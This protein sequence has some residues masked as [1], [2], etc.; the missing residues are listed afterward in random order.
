M[1]KRMKLIL[2]FSPAAAPFIQFKNLLIEW[3]QSKA[4]IDEINWRNLMGRSPPTWLP[5]PQTA[6]IQFPLKMNCLRC[7][8]LPRSRS[9]LVN[10]LRQQATPINLHELNKFISAWFGLPPLRSLWIAFFLHWIQFVFFFCS[11]SL[12]EPLALLAPITPPKKENTKPTSILKLRC[13]RENSN[14][15]N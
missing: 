10:R 9:C 1:K 8:G 7:V 11:L 15:S 4:A 6:T 5:P 3:R 14:K 2:F 12:A 13:L